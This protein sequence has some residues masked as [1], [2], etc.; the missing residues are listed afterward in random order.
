VKAIV[1]TVSD[2]CF[3][4]LRVDAS[5]PQ[6]VRRLQQAGFT[7]DENVVVPDELEQ[8][9]AEIRKQSGRVQ[10]VV[11]TGGTGIAL[12][13]VTPEATRQ[14]CDRILDGFGEHMRR[15]GLKETPLAPMSRAVAGTLGTNLIVN[16]PGS[17]RAALTSL[18]AVLPLIQ[19]ALTLLSGDTEHLELDPT[20]ENK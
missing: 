18:E 17:P 14:V 2:S 3:Q 13:D 7:V 9:A 20:S 4:G 11:T 16:V 6:V 8:I 19:H 10:L 5:G 12:R 1:I 15:E